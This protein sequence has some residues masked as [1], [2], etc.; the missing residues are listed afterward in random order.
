MEN[1][2]VRS[3]NLLLGLGKPTEKSP[4][5][6]PYRAAKTSIS[7]I[8]KPYFKRAAPEHFGVGSARL[9]AMLT[10]LEADSGSNVHSIMVLKDGVVICEASHPAYDVNTRHLSHSMSKTVTAFA[11]GMLVGDGKLDIN[12][13]VED[14]FPESKYKDKRFHNMRIKH[15]LAMS[16]GAS[17]N[18]VGSVTEENWTDAFFASPLIFSPGEDFAYN[19]MNSYILSRIVCKISGMSMTRFLAKRLFEPLRITNYFWEKSPEGFEK[20]GW[21]LY[22]S[23]ES[24]A[25]LGSLCL[26]VG[27]FEGKRI[28][29]ASWIRTMTSTQSKVAESAG[30]FDY[31][32]HVW[33]HRKNDE[34][35]F[36][37]MLGQNVWVCPRNGIVVALTAGNNEMFQNSSTMRIVRKYLSCEIRDYFDFHSRAVLKRTVRDFFA[38]RRKRLPL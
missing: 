37:G 18:E 32:Y 29:P 36:N 38:A 7:G 5:V 28:I 16:S 31:G 15:L 23:T 3:L 34:Y 6:I 2:Q 35:L 20:G 27:V 26:S 9:T 8:E 11:I 33:V 25:K 21:G 4:S 22:L 30:D 12:D 14:F 24:W 10:E 13:R 19:S 1:W 17:F